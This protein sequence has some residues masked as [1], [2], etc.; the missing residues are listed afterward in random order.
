MN[1]L[2]GL[3]PVHYGG[4]WQKPTNSYLDSLLKS[5]IIPPY[6]LFSNFANLRNKIPDP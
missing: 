3:L 2:G 6:F 5:P 4:N 1:S